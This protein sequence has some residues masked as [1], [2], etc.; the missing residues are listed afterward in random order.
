MSIYSNTYIFVFPSINQGIQPPTE[1]IS[2]LLKEGF[3]E[4][5]SIYLSTISVE[6]SPR[7][8][9][10][11]RRRSV[12]RIGFTFAEFRGIPSKSRKN[13]TRNFGTVP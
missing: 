1:E 13:C 6:Q 5:H 7:F 4:Y 12:F 8:L 9:S 11:R 2:L 3:L 10:F